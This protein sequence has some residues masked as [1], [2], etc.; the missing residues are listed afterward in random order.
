MDSIYAEHLDIAARV[1]PLRRRP[2][3]CSSRARRAGR[4]ATS[5]SASRPRSPTACGSSRASRPRG[6]AMEIAEAVGDELLWAGAAEAYG[7]HALVAGRL[8]EGFAVLER[9]FEAADRHQR[10]FLAFM[11]ANIQRPVHVGP[12]RARRGAG[13][14]RAAAAPAVR[15][16]RRLPPADRRRHRPLPRLARRDRRPRAA[17][18]PTRRRPGSPTRSS[19]SSTSG[20]ATWTRS[21]RWPRRRSRRAA[22]PATAGTSGPR[23]HLAAR[24]RALRGEHAAR[25]R[26][27]RGGARAIVVDG[28]APYFEL[29]V[30]PDLA[31][32]LAE[33]GRV[34]EAR[35][36]VDRCRAIAGRRRG[37]AR[38][39]GHRRRR[40]GGRARARGRA[41]RG[42]A[43]LRGGARGARAPRLCAATR[44]TP[45]TSGAALL[46]AARAA[47]RGGRALP[48][49]G[50]GALWLDRVEADR[51]VAR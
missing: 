35:A 38:T 18:S 25:R 24:V 15:R 4:A 12:R 36:H 5:R 22:G 3:A 8:R 26:A 2:R 40:R 14:L 1:P 32:A 31:R 29:W 34:E 10:P 42:R 6:A 39:R 46:G 45:C 19:R 49:H 17:C 11:A 20:T 43:R 13:P 23:S 7:W 41:G 48:P 16:R 37:L 9:A 28:G 30:R 44:P 21:R 27:A 50:A 33:L 51:R 47:R